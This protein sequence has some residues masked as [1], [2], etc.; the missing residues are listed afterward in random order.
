MQWHQLDHMQTVCN[1]LQ[2]PSPHHS[3][4]TCQMLFLTS[5]QQCQNP[6]GHI[7]LRSWLLRVFSIS[8]I[9]RNLLFVCA[10]QKCGNVLSW[11]R[12]QGASGKLQGRCCYCFSL[13]Q[14]SA[15]SLSVHMHTHLSDSTWSNAWLACW[16]QAQ[17]AR[18]QIAAATLSRNSLRQTVHTHYTS[19]HQAAKLVAALLRVAG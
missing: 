6:E 8:I 13:L 9:I 11:K 19:V 14:P 15:V 17:K 1:L 2:T 18:V 5:S 3:I 4:F 12:V 10:E 16:T 7:T